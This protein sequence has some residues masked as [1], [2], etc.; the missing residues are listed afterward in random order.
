MSRYSLNVKQKRKLNTNDN[1]GNF[2]ELKALIKQIFY[3]FLIKDLVTEDSSD[4]LASDVEYSK[5]N[6]SYWY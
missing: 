3:N 4:N 2:F 1:S 6:L 5:V